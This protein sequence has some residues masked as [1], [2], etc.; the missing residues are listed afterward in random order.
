MT[1]IHVK[2]VEIIA[3]T[4]YKRENHVE[5]TDQILEEG[6]EGT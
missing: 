3:K 1:I 5:R 4:K 6:K 2:N